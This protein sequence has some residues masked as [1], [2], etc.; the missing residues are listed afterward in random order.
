MLG[1]YLGSLLYRDVFVM[2]FFRFWLEP[3][4]S[5]N[6]GSG[7]VGKVF[8]VFRFC[9]PPT[10][11]VIHTKTGP[12]F[13]VLSERLEKPWFKLTTPALQGD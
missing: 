4:H 5:S 10:A 7:P 6:T 3:Y 9:V 12:R 13:K 2:L 1:G 8:V 11:K